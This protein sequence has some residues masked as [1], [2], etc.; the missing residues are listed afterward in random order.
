MAN[1]KWRERRRRAALMLFGLIFG[2]VVAEIA[3]RIIGYSYPEFYVTDTSRGYA[4]RPNTSGWYRKENEV[5]VQINSDGLRDREHVKTKPANTIRIAIV[6]DSYA[7]ALQVPLEAAFWQILQTRLPSCDGNSKQIEVI[8][9]GVSGY[10]TAQELITL[11]EHVWEYSPDVVLLAVTTNNDITDNLRELKKAKD[12]PYFT[13]KDDQL[14]LDDSFRSTA[15]F[16]W[17]E[18]ATGRFGR[19]FR[20]HFRVVQAIMEGHRAARLR[21]AAWRTKKDPMEVKAAPTQPAVRS[22]ELG[23]DNLIY[24]E[25]AD[26][27]WKNAWTIT[28][29]LLATMHNEVEAHHAKFLVVTLSNGIQVTP[30][31]QVREEFLKRV[32]ATDLFYP[33]HRIKELGARNG[34]EVINLAPELLGYAERNNIF[35]HGFGSDLGSGHWNEKGHQLAGEILSQKMCG[36]GWLK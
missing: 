31:V 19:W 30:S 35:L 25:P 8:N 15:D 36:G 10:G 4:L 14:V 5:Y 7:E 23:A 24:R 12:I 2:L 32:G 16:E 1:S 29:K 3:L 9:F 34:F 22:E 21:W 26:E 28:E 33:D 20:D 18:S 11:R 27:T 17:R 13:L 6:G